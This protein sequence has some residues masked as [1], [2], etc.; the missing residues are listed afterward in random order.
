MLPSGP[1]SQLLLALS[2]LNLTTTLS[3]PVPHGMTSPSPHSYAIQSPFG[4]LTLFQLPSIAYTNSNQEFTL[5]V[6]LTVFYSLFVIPNACQIPNEGSYTFK[7]RMHAPPF[8]HLTPWSRDAQCPT[9]SLLARPRGWSPPRGCLHFLSSA[10]NV[11]LG[12][13]HSLANLGIS[14]KPLR[15]VCPPSVRLPHHNQTSVPATYLCCLNLRIFPLAL[16]FSLFGAECELPSRP[17][18][19]SNPAASTPIPTVIFRPRTDAHSLRESPVTSFAAPQLPPSSYYPSKTRASLSQT[20]GSRAL[21]WTRNSGALPIV[22]NGPESFPNNHQA[23][24]KH[25]SVFKRPITPSHSS[26]CL[27]QEPIY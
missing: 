19:H 16:M 22:A 18:I 3:W 14:P 24:N 17:Q 23:L 4:R 12:V 13:A 20:E 2:G 15:R 5:S 21:P 9:S 25:P 7:I 11:N 1:L 6:C 27:G 10:R 26:N 8:S